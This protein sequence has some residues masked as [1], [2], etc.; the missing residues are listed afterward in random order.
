MR[1]V[2]IYSGL[3]SSGLFFDQDWQ[4]RLIAFLKYFLLMRETDQRTSSVSSI[5]RRT[6]EKSTSPVDRNECFYHGFSSVKYVHFFPLKY[7]D[8]EA[9]RCIFGG[10]NQQK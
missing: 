2:R 6:A 8:S 7:A 4:P 9:K 5:A 1:T 10:S 3:S